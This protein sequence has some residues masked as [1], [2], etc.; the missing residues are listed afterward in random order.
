MD[1]DIEESLRKRQRKHPFIG[2][3]FSRKKFIDYVGELLQ[4]Y[5][6]RREQVR[7]IKELYGNQIKELYHSLP[8][9][10]VE[11]VLDD[12]DSKVTVSLRY[13]D[14]LSVLP[15]RIRVLAWP[16]KKSST[17]GATLNR[18]ENGIVG[19]HQIPARLSYAEDALQ[20]MSLPEG[21]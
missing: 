8:Y 16:S 6:D 18:K 10:M 4:A 5:V 14:L 19:S 12:S 11:F 17:I 21:V 7:L 15:T 13:A 1:S 20:T 9:H 2:D 3:S